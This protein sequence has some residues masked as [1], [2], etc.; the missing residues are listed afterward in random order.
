MTAD[1]PSRGSERSKNVAVVTI[2]AGRHDHL[3][4]QQ[5]GL[6][7][8]R[9][10][11]DIYVVVG[12]GDEDALAITRSGPLADTACT[13]R[14]ISLSPTTALPLAA[15]RNAGAAAALAA[16]AETLIFL[17][18]DC[19]PSTE[20]VPTYAEA[21]ADESDARLYC[22]VV[23]YLPEGADAAHPIKTGD[24]IGR[25]HELRPD[26]GTGQF[27][28]S[29]DWPLFW[30]LSFAVSAST[31]SAIGGFCEA[32]H[33]YGAE[34]TDLGYRAHRKSIDIHWLGG[35]DV[36]HQ[37][38]ETSSPPIQHLTDIVA[39]AQTFHSLW[40]FWPMLGWLRR[41]RELGLTHYDEELDRW[42][43]V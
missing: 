28:V 1:R 9:R 38:H 11:P 24:P 23:R 42:E 16:G 13:V 35:A 22:G 29:D 26:P 17:D 10:V 31:W 25:P 32:Y 12:M 7:T 2:V 6:A 8:G 14:C 40:G 27:E 21:V 5:R 41:F 20:T 30:S 3:R 36:F 33:G 39:N 34:D 4:N 18:V 15:A 37:F 43:L 19:V